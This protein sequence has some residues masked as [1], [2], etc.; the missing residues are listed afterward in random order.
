VVFAHGYS[1]VRKQSASYCRHLASRGYVVAS[2]DFPLSKLFAPGG[3]NVEAVL[4][5]PGD[6]SFVIDCLL[7]ANRS[8]GHPLRGAVDQTRIGI[9]G[10]SLGGLTALLAAYGT[11][12]DPRVRAIVTFAPHGWFVPSDL[13]RGTRVPAMVIGGTKDN[14]VNPA[15]IRAG[16]DAASPPKWFVEIAGA[17]HMRFADVHFDDRIILWLFGWLPGFGRPQAGVGRVVR[18]LGGD[19]KA[20][21]H[22]VDTRPGKRISGR[23]QRELMRAYATPFLDAFLKEDEVAMSLLREMEGMAPE[24]RIESAGA[25]TPVP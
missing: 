6:V 19:M 11:R 24:A 23:R 12:R 25:L 9:S 16:Y 1:G 13:S 10:H 22:P 5:Q 14:V 17:E 15:S 20:W 2:P 4:E 8:N 3:P 7:A 18:A 21:D